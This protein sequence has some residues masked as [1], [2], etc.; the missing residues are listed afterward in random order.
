MTLEERCVMEDVGREVR[1]KWERKENY[2]R[3]IFW[4]SSEDD[5]VIVHD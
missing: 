2:S 1:A 4:Y 3:T 5:L